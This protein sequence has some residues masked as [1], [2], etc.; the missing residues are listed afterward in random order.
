MNGWSRRRFGVVTVSAALA[1]GSGKVDIA[2]SAAESSFH[3]TS[4]G[5]SLLDGYFDRFREIL[6]TFREREADSIARAADA[7]V[8][9]IGRGGILYNSLIGHLFYKNGGEIGPNRIGN[10]VLFIR[11]AAAAKVGDFLL[12]M[13]PMEAKRAKDKGVFCVGV[14]S[15]YFLQEETPPLALAETPAEVLR[16]PDNLMLS[17][18]CDITIRTHVPV[19]EG[20]LEPPRISTPL[21]PATS[22]IT[23]ILYWALAGEIAVRLARKGI[24]VRVAG[25]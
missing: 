18:V 2:T 15:P 12:T 20:I 13:S 16:N 5:E 6:D 7:A 1:I 23:A 3:S 10:P 8:A 25:E 14:T 24:P 22:Q 17:Q 19:V 9:C 4:S 11:D 21:I